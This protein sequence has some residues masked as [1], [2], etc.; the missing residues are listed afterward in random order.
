MEALLCLKFLLEQDDFLCKIDLEDAYFE[1]PLS[2]QSTKFV[3]WLRNL[4]MFLP[5]Y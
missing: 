4:Q 2:K 1:F 3:R 5:N